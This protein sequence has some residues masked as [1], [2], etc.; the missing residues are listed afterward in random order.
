MVPGFSRFVSIFGNLEKFGRLDGRPFGASPHSP[1]PLSPG[2][3]PTPPGERGLKES[4]R[5]KL[6]FSLFSRRT[7]GR[8]GEEGRGDE[9][10]RTEDAKSDSVELPRQRLF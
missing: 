2:L 9:G 4:S 10:Q 6:P 3:P 8:P 5:Y 1:N 7:G